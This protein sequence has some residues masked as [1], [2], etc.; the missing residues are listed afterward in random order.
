M[1][2]GAFCL[3]RGIGPARQRE[4]YAKNIRAWDDFPDSGVV[5]S[6]T[7][8]ARLREAL[9][10]A[11]ALVA[12]RRWLELSALLPVRE[13]WRL[14]SRLEG[15]ATYLD[16]E[17]TADGQ[18]TVIGLWDPQRGPRLYV[19]GYNLGRFV[20][21]S[22]PVVVTFN[23]GSFDLPVL[24]RSF[25]RWR[26]QGLHIDMRTVMGRLGERGGLKA[27]E[28]RL[29]IGRP[30][31]LR[32]VDGSDAIAL[33]NEFRRSA[34]QKALWRLLE[35][36]LYD[37]IQLRSVAQIACERL[38]VGTGRRWAPAETFRRADAAVDVTRCV[39]AVVEHASR[40]EPDAFD[41][42]ERVSLRG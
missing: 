40:I 36:N 11:R 13:H 42:E 20:E 12:G 26:F 9:V 16:I 2:D 33:W 41:D 3:V 39:A 38:A 10:S 8:D 1:I 23:G 25:P 35:Y 4:L 24:R 6:K 7:L 34:S 15:E 37:V 31:H 32:G 14:L 19:R 18:I 29:G 27:I 17:T 28:Q 5:L 30:E 21:E 22:L